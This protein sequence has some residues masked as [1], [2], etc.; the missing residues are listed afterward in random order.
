MIVLCL[1]PPYEFPARIELMDVEFASRLQHRLS[2]TLPGRLIQERCAVEMSFGRHF[3]P[4]RHDAR[5]AAVM[6]LLYYRDD[7][8]VLPLIVRPPDA[9]HHAGQVS[10]PGGAIEKGETPEEAALREVEEELGVARNA[11]QL[12]GRLSPLYVFA[13]NHTVEPFVGLLSDQPFLEVNS[14]EVARLLEAPVNYLLTPD[15]LAMS[16][17]VERGIRIKAPA[18]H[19]DGEPIWGATAMIVAELIAV[20]R[21]A[22]PLQSIA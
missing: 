6:A 20:I 9:L 22:Q 8:W 21:D 18:Y 7:R 15:S 3:G 19:W 17:R 1:H 5:P 16:E 13:S 11:I 10:L 12:L 2:R 14:L 4:P